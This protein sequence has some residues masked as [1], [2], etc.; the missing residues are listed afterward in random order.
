MLGG[1]PVHVPL[2]GSIKK[3]NLSVRSTNALN[4]AG[5]KTIKDLLDT[6][7]NSIE[8]IYGLGV[9]SLNEIYSIRENLKL[10]YN[11]DLKL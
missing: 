11:H 8:K 9:K 3:L 10:I 2:E 1:I 4:R 5:I 7:Q 6:P